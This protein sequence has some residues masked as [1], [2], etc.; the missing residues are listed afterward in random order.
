MFFLTV[1]VSAKILSEKRYEHKVR[2][3]K[4]LVTKVYEYNED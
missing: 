1:N 2:I 3:H 4:T